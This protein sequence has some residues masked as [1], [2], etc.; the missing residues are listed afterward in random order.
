MQVGGDVRGGEGRRGNVLD[1]IASF[2]WK[3]GS[4]DTPEVGMYLY[5]VHYI[6]I[7]TRKRQN[8]V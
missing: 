1:L 3:A 7:S 4:Q 5:N 2:E 6:S 8:V